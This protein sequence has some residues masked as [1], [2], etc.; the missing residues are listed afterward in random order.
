MAM[1]IFKSP[2]AACLSQA[3]LRLYAHGPGPAFAANVVAMLRPLFPDSIV[4]V[5]E[6]FYDS[7][8]FASH[9]SDGFVPEEASFF[10][11]I[12]E[13]AFQNPTV[14]YLMERGQEPIIQFTD[15]LSLRQFRRREVY[16]QGYRH[17]DF[18]DQITINLPGERSAVVVGLTGSRPYTTDDRALLAF[19]RPHILQAKANT[20]WI[21]AADRPHA[22]PGPHILELTLARDGTI[23]DWPPAARQILDYFYG[24]TRQPW[25]P[26]PDLLSWI[27]DRRRDLAEGRVIARR[28]RPLLLQRGPRLLRI[29][30]TRT[31]DGEKEVLAFS[32]FMDGIVQGPRDLTAR[33]KEVLHWIGQGKTNA[34]IALILGISPHTVKKHVEHLLAKLGVEN[35]V[36]LATRGL[37][38]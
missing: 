33:E 5:D 17:L 6:M 3:L 13:Y 29:S 26:P 37:R 38:A 22:G 7:A 18:R 16:Q 14:A 28:A 2:E 23:T 19:L 30:L 12:V 32:G 20:G 9:A 35:R 8:G 24:A 36:A 1:Q 25:S 15:F 11:A 10:P 34:E 27:K 21:S 4:T 31:I